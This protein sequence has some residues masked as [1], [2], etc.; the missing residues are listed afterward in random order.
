MGLKLKSVSCGVQNAEVYQTLC[1]ALELDPSHQ[2]AL[3]MKAR[4]LEEA[5]RLRSVAVKYLLLGQR[6]GALSKISLAIDCDPEEAE[7]HVLK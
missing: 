1:Q 6:E 2:E 4:Q 5:R 3:E 7:F